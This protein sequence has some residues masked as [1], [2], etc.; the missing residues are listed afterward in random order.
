MRREVHYRHSLYG[1]RCGENAMRCDTISDMS[2]VANLHLSFK[3]CGC[4]LRTIG[5]ARV[6]LVLKGAHSACVYV[7]ICKHGVDAM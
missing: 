5:T 3:F 7:N 1:S 2:A 4:K 6:K